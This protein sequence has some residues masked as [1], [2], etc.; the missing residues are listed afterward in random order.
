MQVEKNTNIHS[1]SEWRLKAHTISFKKKWSRHYSSFEFF[2]LITEAEHIFTKLQN[3]QFNS[4]LMETTRLLIKE[5]QYRLESNSLDM[6]NEVGAI[7]NN[8]DNK[9]KNVMP[10]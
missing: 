2:Q 10:K 1:L 3:D 9:I 6:S 5:I 8:I 4:E 7:S